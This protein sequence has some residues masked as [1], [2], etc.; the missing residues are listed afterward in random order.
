M[1]VFLMMSNYFKHNKKNIYK[2]K[3]KK[4]IISN[5]EKITS[6][7]KNVLFF[8]PKLSFIWLALHIKTTNEMVNIK[9]IINEFPFTH[10]LYSSVP[11]KGFFLPYF[12]FCVFVRTSIKF[13]H[14]NTVSPMGSIAI[15]LRFTRECVF[16]I[17]SNCLKHSQ[18]YLFKKK[19]ISNSV[20][21]YFK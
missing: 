15:L 11:N 2:K 4:R 6:L 19:F 13:K 3:K 21:N 8:M 12:N 16:L 14:V 9:N 7:K 1:G 17:M 5:T 10:L 20:K 18:N